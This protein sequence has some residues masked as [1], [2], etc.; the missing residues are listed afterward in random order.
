MPIK[1]FKVTHLGDRRNRDNFTMQI[2]LNSEQEN[3]LAQKIDISRKL[4]NSYQPNPHR[5]ALA[6]SFSNLCEE[7]QALHAHRPLTDEEIAEEIAAYRRG[8]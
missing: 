8:E 5:Q 7:T 2:I 3:L 6:E 1:N 4:K